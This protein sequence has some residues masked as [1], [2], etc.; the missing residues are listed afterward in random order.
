MNKR[1]TK[2][3]FGERGSIGR[4]LFGR[5]R[6]L[7]RR[8]VPSALVLLAVMFALL[9]GERVWGYSVM[10]NDR[11]LLMNNDGKWGAA[12]TYQGYYNTNTNDKTYWVHDAVS[13]G[14][15]PNLLRGVTHTMYKKDGTQLWHLVQCRAGSATV[16]NDSRNYISWSTTAKSITNVNGT[17]FIPT[18]DAKSV[19]SVIFRN[20]EEACLYS[21][22]YNEGIGTIYWDCGLC[23]GNHT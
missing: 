20:T 6:S 12:I 11:I 22:C 14:F 7:S 2:C 19:G 13:P 8:S 4:P 16:I 5:L 23:C 18:S 21:P 9:S 1:R 10:D 17:A 15:T 3:W